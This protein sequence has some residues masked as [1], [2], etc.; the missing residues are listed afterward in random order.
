MDKFIDILNKYKKFYLP[1]IYILLA[2]LIYVIIK[3]IIKVAFHR[4][5]EK[6]KRNFNKQETIIKFFL[7]I[8]KVIITFATLL[9]IL[10]LY[11]VNVAAFI[12]GL[13]IFGAA[14]ALGAQ[15]FLKDIFAGISIIFEDYF[16]IGDVIEFD[17]FKGEV[18]D[19]S[20]RTTKIKKWDGDVMIVNNKLF[21][22]VINNSEF[23]KT[24][25]IDIILDR[26]DDLEKA[27]SVIED[28][29]K[30]YTPKTEENLKDSPKILGLTDVD[31]NT[32]VL[33]IIA[34]CLPETH[35]GIERKI[36]KDVY[37]KLEENNFN[38]PYERIKIQDGKRI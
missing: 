23:N 4:K 8:I 3:K 5:G 15:D 19:L 14:I 9:A 6:N 18:I 28:V 12:T 32:K 27:I 2:I 16:S 31:K 24:A 29:L 34:D 17:D 10:S 33:R 1:F 35:Y 30:N 20:L 25:S 11:G 26:S 22:K 13:G 38:V 36:R 37:L 21:D 7:N